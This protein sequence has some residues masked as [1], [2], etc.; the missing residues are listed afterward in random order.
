MQ[1]LAP[2]IGWE[3]FHQ[4]MQKD[5]DGLWQIAEPCLYYAYHKQFEIV[6]PW[7]DL[8]Y[9]EGNGKDL[10][11]WGRISALAALSDRINLSSLLELGLII[12]GP[13]AAA[14]AGAGAGAAT[15][16][17][18][19]ALVGWGMPEERVKRYDEGLRKG[20]ILMGFRP[21]NDDDAEYINN[22]WTSSRAQDVYR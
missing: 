12:A 7:L 6:Q 1:H 18:V 4:A 21:R 20:G 9:R 13:L 11:T 17:L 19:G 8:L 16:G 2:D 3:M 15:G 14:I 22:T 10:E 5:A